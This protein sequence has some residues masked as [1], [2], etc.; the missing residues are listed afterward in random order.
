MQSARDF[1]FPSEDMGK[2]QLLPDCG[3]QLWNMQLIRRAPSSTNTHGY[4]KNGWK[5]PLFSISRLRRRI[6]REKGLIQQ[7]R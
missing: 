7:A 1:G 5:E 2:K 4:E 3:Q 6:S